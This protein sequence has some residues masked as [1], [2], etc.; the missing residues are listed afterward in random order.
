M[1]VCFALTDAHSLLI[2]PVN[3]FC[4]KKTETRLHAQYGNRR[5]K[6]W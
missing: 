2:D 4:S 3:S 6:Q 1:A 5:G